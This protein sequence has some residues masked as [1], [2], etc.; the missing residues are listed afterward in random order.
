MNILM[1]VLALSGWRTDPKDGRELL[2]AMHDRYN[3]KWY[4]TLTF[5]QNN[6][7]YLPGHKL[8]FYGLP[9]RLTGA[10]ARP[11][12]EREVSRTRHRLRHACLEVHRNAQDRRDERSRHDRSGIMHVALGR[13]LHDDGHRVD[14]DIGD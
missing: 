4:K 13:S 6:T 10:D 14:D 9:E 12:A 7:A 8:P 2:R 3:G 11:D 5:V 1:L